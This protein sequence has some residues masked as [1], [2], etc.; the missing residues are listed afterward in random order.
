MNLKELNIPG[1]V[2]ITQRIPISFSGDLPAECIRID[3]DKC[4]ALV[5]IALNQPINP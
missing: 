5:E 3:C 1:S 4:Y 2:S